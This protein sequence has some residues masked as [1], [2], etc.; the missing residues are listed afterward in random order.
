MSL[1]TCFLVSLKTYDLLFFCCDRLKWPTELMYSSSAWS[2]WWLCFV[3]LAA[4]H[5]V[6]RVTRLSRSARLGRSV[7][8]V[9]CVGILVLWQLGV[10]SVRA[11][12][13]SHPGLIQYT[14]QHQSIAFPATPHPAAA[15]VNPYLSAP[16]YPVHNLVLCSWMPPAHF[17]S[18]AAAPMVLPLLLCPLAVLSLLVLAVVLLLE[19]YLWWVSARHGDTNRKKKQQN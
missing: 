9:P 14:R 12:E 11:G 18:H 8:I 15:V 16:G 3:T 1:L 7:V 6:S 10:L 17:P 4:I 2:A 5:R 19:D 13:A